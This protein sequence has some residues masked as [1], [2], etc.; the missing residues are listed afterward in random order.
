MDLCA[1]ILRYGAGAG[2]AG[3][4]GARA[5][6]LWAESGVPAAVIHCPVQLAA[7]VRIQDT[8]IG[9]ALARG[10]RQGEGTVAIH[11]APLGR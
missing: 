3:A 11:Q 9:K 1:F 8:A 7:L 6:A 2:L 5:I 10:H 4:A